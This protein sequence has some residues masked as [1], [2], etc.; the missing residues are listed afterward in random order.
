[1]RRLHAFFWGKRCILC[2][3][4]TRIGTYKSRWAQ[5]RIKGDSNWVELNNTGPSDVLGR[6]G[7]LGGAGPGDT[8]CKECS[9]L[10]TA[11]YLASSFLTICM[12]CSGIE[13]GYN[14]L[15][16]GYYYGENA[17]PPIDSKCH[18]GMFISTLS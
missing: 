17:V 6:G 4:S 2:R 10:D 18:H 16:S 1:M 8:T 15:T 7:D 11:E 12:D 5:L 9:G 13:A 3:T 14:Q